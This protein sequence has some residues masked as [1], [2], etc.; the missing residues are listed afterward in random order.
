MKRTKRPHHLREDPSFIFDHR[1]KKKKTEISPDL[2][3]EQYEPGDLVWSKLGNFPWWP[4]L[5]VSDRAILSF[6]RCFSIAAKMKMVL[7][8]ELSLD[9]NVNT[10]FISTVHVL[11]ALGFP[12]D[13]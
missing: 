2:H 12:P 1:P 13:L 7:L 5:V 10:S 4:A 3:A 11:N 9:H 6:N 8:L